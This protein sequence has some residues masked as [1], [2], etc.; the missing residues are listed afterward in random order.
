MDRIGGLENTTRLTSDRSYNVTR[1]LRNNFTCE[2]YFSLFLARQQLSQ[3]QAISVTNAYTSLD[4]FILCDTSFGNT[5]IQ[6]PLIYILLSCGNTVTSCFCHYL[7][8][9]KFPT[10]FLVLEQT[11]VLPAIGLPELPRGKH[12][13]LDHQLAHTMNH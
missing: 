12:P 5:C 9:S 2:V 1:Y 7:A 11:C 6:L 3:Y 13:L 10:V 4:I 8:V